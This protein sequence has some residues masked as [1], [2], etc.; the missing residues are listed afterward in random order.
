MSTEKTID[1]IESGAVGKVTVAKCDCNDKSIFHDWD[2]QILSMM[3]GIKQCNQ[4]VEDDKKGKEVKPL[5]EKQKRG[6]ALKEEEEKL[7]EL[8]GSRLLPSEGEA[9][10]GFQD[11]YDSHR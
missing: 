3:A 8:D 5:L 11:Y 1:S 2:D 10:S 4:V 9:E 6:E 7:L